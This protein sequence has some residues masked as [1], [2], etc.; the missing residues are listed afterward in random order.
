MKGHWKQNMFWAKHQANMYVVCY[1]NIPSQVLG[2][3]I[4]IPAG[5]HYVDHKSVYS[6]NNKKVV[7]FVREQRS[8][9]KNAIAEADK[10]IR[11]NRI[12]TAHQP[13]DAAVKLQ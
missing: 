5:K 7:Y 11:L 4:L 1:W 10:K 2:S 13:R 6:N 3:M 12:T 9:E 8:V